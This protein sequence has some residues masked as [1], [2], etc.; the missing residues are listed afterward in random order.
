MNVHWTESALA[1]LHAA[2]A[3]IARHS[4]RYATSLVDRIFART[5]QLADY[6]QLGGMVPEYGEESLREVFESPYRIIYRVLE[7]QIDVVAVVHASRRL[8]RAMPE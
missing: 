4:T 6:P 2:E 5:G 7:Y 8:P 3:S 1:D